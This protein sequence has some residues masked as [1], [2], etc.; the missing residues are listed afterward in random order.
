MTKVFKTLGLGSDI[1][2]FT[3]NNMSI[4]I[5]KMENEVHAQVQSLRMISPIEQH[6]L[7]RTFDNL[8]GVSRDERMINQLEIQKRIAIQEYIK[9]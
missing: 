4:A 7:R 9:E 6:Q 5:N 3:K 1:R 2:T 8:A